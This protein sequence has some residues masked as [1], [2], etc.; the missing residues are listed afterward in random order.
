MLTMTSP[1][2]LRTSAIAGE[3]STLLEW[4]TAEF[5]RCFNKQPFLIRHRLCENPLFSVERLLKLAQELPE[6]DIEYNAGNLPIN[7]DPD[8]TPRN[9]LS[10]AD[11]VRRIKECKS[12]MVLKH[13]ENDPAYG[14]V[15]DDCLAEVR[16][17]S[18][19]IVPGMMSAHAY[20]FLTSPGSIT[21]YHMDPE[22]NFLLQIHGSK[23]VHLFDGN[24][25]SIV[26]QEDFERFYGGRVRNMTLADENRS[27]SWVFDLQPG[28]GLHF[29]VTYPHFVQNCEEVSVSLS[30][31][32]RTPDL[33][34]R[35]GIHSINWKLRQR[36][37]KPAPVGK[38]RLLDW[39]KYQY[40]RAARRLNMI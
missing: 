3:N 15:L 33:D 7:Q 36:G 13:V 28:Y 22:H 8:L 16:T 37:W 26:S 4:D 23:I 21:P 6:N 5:D 29:P 17:Q 1:N 32:F 18:E 38:H 12:W 10:V 30:I 11:T 20:I 34:R 31:T 24:D 9:G 35:L 27:K 39:G 19:A 25:P 2:S 14:K 40:Y